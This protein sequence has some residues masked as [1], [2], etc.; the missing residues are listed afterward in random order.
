MNKRSASFLV[1][2]RNGREINEDGLTNVLMYQPIN[3]RFPYTHIVC[4]HRGRRN[5]LESSSNDSLLLSSLCAGPRWPNC[6]PARLSPRVKWAQYPAGSLPDSRMWESCRTM[7][8][9]GGSY[10][11]ISRFPVLSFRC[12]SNTHL[13]HPHRLSRPNIFTDSSLPWRRAR[14]YEFEDGSKSR[15][16]VSGN[17]SRANTPHCD[18]RYTLTEYGDHGFFVGNVF[19][20]RARS[21]RCDDVTYLSAGFLP[22]FTVKHNHDNTLRSAH[23]Y[24]HLQQII[25]ESPTS[26]I[27]RTPVLLVSVLELAVALLVHTTSDS[28]LC[29]QRSLLVGHQPVE[30][31]ADIDPMKCP[32]SKN[33]VTARQH[34]KTPPANELLVTYLLTYRS[35]NKL[36]IA[37][38]SKP[39]R[40][41]DRSHGVAHPISECWV[42]TQRNHQEISASELCS[43]PTSLEVS[44]YLHLRYSHADNDHECEARC[45]AVIGW[46]Q[47]RKKANQEHCWAT[48]RPSPLLRHCL[49]QYA[50]QVRKFVYLPSIELLVLQRKFGQHYNIGLHGDVTVGAKYGH[51]H[52]W[53]EFLRSLNIR[54]MAH[55]VVSGVAWTNRTMVSSN[56]DTNRTGVLAIVDI[57]D[58]VMYVVSASKCVQTSMLELRV[59]PGENGTARNARVGDTI[60]T[61][62]RVQ[63]NKRGYGGVDSAA[64]GY[65][66]TQASGGVGFNHVPV[67]SALQTESGSSLFMPTVLRPSGTRGKRGRGMPPAFCTVASDLVL[68]LCPSG[69]A[70]HKKLEPGET[71]CIAAT[72]ERAARH[73]L[74]TCCDVNCTSNFNWPMITVH[75]TCPG[76]LYAN[77]RL[78]RKQVVSAILPH[79]EQHW[80]SSQLKNICDLSVRRTVESSQQ[81]RNLSHEPTETLSYCARN[82]TCVNLRSP[83]M[84][85]VIRRQ[86][87]KLEILSISHNNFWFDSRS[88]SYAGIVPDDAAGRRVIPG[89][90]SFPSPLH[91]GAAPYSSRFTLV[92]RPRS[93]LCN[94]TSPSQ[95]FLTAVHDEV[96]TFEINLRNTS[97]P[98]HAYISTGAL[99]DMRPV[100]L[101]TMGGNSEG[102]HLEPSRAGD[103]GSYKDGGNRQRPVDSIK[104]NNRTSCGMCIGFLKCYLG[105]QRRRN[106]ASFTA[107]YRTWSISHHASR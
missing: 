86:G 83:D 80:G 6:Q 19:F 24:S 103:R 61:Y 12:G 9:V 89:V 42:L 94:F 87:I 49:C 23:V 99:S 4:H 72:H 30:S 48:G 22:T 33:G 81:R 16:A 100:K 102:I 21:L 1:Y 11:G 60:P 45:G 56:T 93:C 57:G 52:T 51:V 50:Q 10:S 97:L 65:L 66:L 91:S 20:T 15:V 69:A 31:R 76:R 2:G 101:V 73:P 7:P 41:E 105:F 18:H 38:H 77:S 40:L 27:V 29:F 68:T 67:L 75:Y 25:S 78:A 47:P 55:W 35:A 107:S 44:E 82:H 26:T 95:C 39:I 53:K 98:L 70:C 46:A 85:S 64:R 3:N 84:A 104:T 54:N 37:A 34:F 59:K 62:K 8:L 79:V 71:E 5:H 32:L 13:I 96:N 36:Y 88:E 43:A 74:H 90:S 28:T 58:P 92:G 63:S 17:W 14:E 106:T